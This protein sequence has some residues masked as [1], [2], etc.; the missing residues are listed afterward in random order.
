MTVSTY[1]SH[2]HKLTLCDLGTQRPVYSRTSTPSVRSAWRTYPGTPWPSGMI[3]VNHKRKFNKIFCS[4]PLPKGQTQ[5]STFFWIY[6]II[7]QSRQVWLT[8]NSKRTSTTKQRWSDPHFAGTSQSQSSSRRRMTS[9][10]WSPSLSA[11]TV[12]GRFTKSA[13][14]TSSRSGESKSTRNV[15]FSLIFV[16]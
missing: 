15:I 2:K 10:R 6:K 9:W 8:K 7:L 13:F 3:P 4:M 12:A 14:F 5:F 1:I 11:Q 16:L